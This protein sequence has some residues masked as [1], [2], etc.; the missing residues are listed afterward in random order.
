MATSKL[1][2][3]QYTADEFL[4]CAGS[5]L[6]RH[7]PHPRPETSSATASSLSNLPPLQV[8]LIL[9]TGRQEWLLP[10]GRK[11]RFE[12]ITATATRETFEETGYPCKLLPLTL[13]TRAPLPGS[14]TK[15]CVEVVDGCE[16]PFMMTL[17]NV[18]NG[19]ENGKVGGVKMIWWFVTVVD[20]AEEEKVEGTQTAVESYVSEF[21][22]VGDALERAT[23]QSDR[24]VIRKAVELVN[25]TYGGDIR[26]L[27]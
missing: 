13:A 5:I 3:M 25:E 21:V 6:F 27:L 15:D 24:D 4:V 23:F 26:H 17:R 22:D 16:E 2:T 11:D 10:K 1:P 9:H 18:P 20:K 8:C 14:Q 7:D 12:A 19:G